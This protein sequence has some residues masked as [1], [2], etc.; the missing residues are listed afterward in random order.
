MTLNPTKRSCDQMGV[1][2]GL[3]VDECPNCTAWECEV[4]VPEPKHRV[5]VPCPA[6]RFAP[7]VIE[8]GKARSAYQFKDAR[9]FPLSLGDSAKLLGLLLAL[10]VAAG[11]VVERYL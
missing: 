8:D 3:G 6:F 5:V 1:C 2:Q 7:G 4:A 10:S 9:W 11:Y